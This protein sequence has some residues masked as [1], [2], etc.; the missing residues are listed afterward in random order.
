MVAMPLQDRIDGEH[1]LRISMGLHEPRADV[2]FVGAQRQDR[3][4]QF[5]RH[6]ER[7]PLGPGGLDASDVGRLR[8]CRTAN[9]ERGRAP[10]AVDGDI[11][12][13]VVVTRVVDRALQR[14]EGDTLSVGGPVAA[15]R[16]LVRARFHRVGELSGLDDGVAQPP[17]LGF[18]AA[19]ALVARAEDV[20]EVVAHTP[21]VGDAGE[22]ARSRQDAHQED[23]VAR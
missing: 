15:L 11:D 3:V 4:V 10:C 19:Y 17:I 8:R 22:A 13:P 6:R 12:V 2:E 9:R 16:Q 23:L 21:L 14:R 7:P 1:R 20:G 18:L 5:A